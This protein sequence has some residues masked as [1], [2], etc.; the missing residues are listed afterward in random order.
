M[1]LSLKVLEGKHL[2]TI[3]KVLGQIQTK[4]EVLMGFL[5]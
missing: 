5:H 2:Q 4:V 1:L 3:A